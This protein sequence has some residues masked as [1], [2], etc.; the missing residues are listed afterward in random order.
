MNNQP[1]VSCICITKN[2]LNLVLR[3]IDCFLK[4]TY[5]NKELV[6]TYETNNPYIS[7]F[8]WFAKNYPEIKLIELPE[9][10]K[11]PLGELRNLSIEQSSGQY[12][13]QWD[14]DDW[15]HPERIEYQVSQLTDQY[16]ANILTRWL[17]FD[18][19]TNLAYTSF[20]R[21]WEGSILC[22]K[23]I[24]MKSSKY[25]CL[26]KGE[27][28]DF[29]NN[30]IPHIKELD[31]PKLY[32]YVFHNNNTWYYWHFQNNF[33][34]SIFLGNEFSGTVKK[35]LDGAINL[36]LGEQLELINSIKIEP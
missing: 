5:K 3:S 14:D 34:Q 25:P 10:P 33:K 35:I 2:N 9:S 18:G 28:T 21:K 26:A 30:I 22:S 7:L 31:N 8:N 32:I 13:M 17:M 29:I 6:I 1:L 15:F 20:R 12:F 24:F 36:N 4:Q 16:K 23:D 27:D 11:K 19:L